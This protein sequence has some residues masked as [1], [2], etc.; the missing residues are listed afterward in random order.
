M[1]KF[2][3]ILSIDEPI[4]KKTR[5][6]LL[7][8]ESIVDPLAYSSNDALMATMT[9]IA[10]LLSVPESSFTQQQPALDVLQLRTHATMHNGHIDTEPVQGRLQAVS[11]NQEKRW[12]L[13]LSKISFTK[14]SEE[15][16][17]IL[18]AEAEAFLSDV[19]CTA[20]IST[21]STDYNIAM[22]QANQDA[23]NSDVDEGDQVAPGRTLDSDAETRL[24]IIRSL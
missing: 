13:I 22:F 8:S 20:L 18:D 16:E 21:S 5:K 12:T 17:I 19:E 6:I 24:M 9:Q 7:Q 1:F 15:K 10:N 23:Y 4:A 14:G 11:K 2:I 3:P